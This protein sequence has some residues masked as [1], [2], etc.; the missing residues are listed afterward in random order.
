MLEF[1]K[2]YYI[3]NLLNKPFKISGLNS[4][5]FIRGLQH[6]DC[7]EASRYADKLIILE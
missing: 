1:T 6:R 5:Y 4:Y 3:M 2:W 7:S